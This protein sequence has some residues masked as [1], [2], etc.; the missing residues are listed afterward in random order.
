MEV[1]KS[2]CVHADD[3]HNE[4]TGSKRIQIIFRDIQKQRKILQ[5]TAR[6]DMLQAFE[7]GRLPIFAHFT[8]K[9][10]P[11]HGKTVAKKIQ[12]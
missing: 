12:L 4:D 2:K 8:L 6:R 7:D 11:T 1:R 3:D 10:S 5:S 9:V